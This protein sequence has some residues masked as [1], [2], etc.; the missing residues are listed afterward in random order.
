MK[1]KLTQLAKGIYNVKTWRWTVLVMIAVLLSG[2]VYYALNFLESSR[3]HVTISK[4]E[5]KKGK[6]NKDLSQTD[7]VE[8]EATYEDFNQKYKALSRKIPKAEWKL[9]QREMTD[10]EYQVEYQKYLEAKERRSSLLLDYY[11]Y[12]VTPPDYLYSDPAEPTKTIIFPYSMKGFMDD[13]LKGYDTDSTDFDSK[14]RIVEKMEHFIEMTD[15]KGTDT[16]LIDK[17]KS[18]LVNSKDLS[19]EEI[20][21]VEKLHK[22]VTKT[23]LVFSLTAANSPQE[24]QA[25]LFSMY[26]AAANGEITEARFT[27]LDALVKQLKTKKIKDTVAVLNVVASAMKTDFSKFKEEGESVDEL[28]MQCIDDFFMSGKIEFTKDDVENKFNKYKDLFG[29]KLEAANLEKKAREIL[30]KENRK[31][32]GE[33]VFNG[34]LFAFIGVIVVFLAK[35]NSTLKTNNTL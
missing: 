3:P 16:L 25:E 2:A 4:K 29:K 32:A 30:R 10:A 33:W 31:S 18:L 12:G 1:N 6:I 35:L 21:A 23:P 17:F 7:E 8:S 13:I 22:S 27:Q 15:K 26:E 14:L 28:E 24:R 9:T 11:S 5:L 19:I 20:K 34:L